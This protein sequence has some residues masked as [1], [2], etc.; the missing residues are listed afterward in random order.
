MKYCCDSIDYVKKKLLSLRFVHCVI[1]EK[2]S[3]WQ[4]N[5]P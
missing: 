1:K 2:C 5:W 4:N 3:L